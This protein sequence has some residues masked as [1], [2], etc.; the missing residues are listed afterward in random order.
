M[1]TVY[2]SDEEI[3]F[4]KKKYGG[5]YNNYNKYNTLYEGHKCCIISSKCV[6][7]RKFQSM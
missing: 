1:D 4:R 6:F 2:P 7:E 5:K 3:Q